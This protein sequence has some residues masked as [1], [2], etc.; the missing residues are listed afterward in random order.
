M[1]AL[2]SRAAAGRP[3]CQ[4]RC[5]VWTR[6]SRLQ[7]VCQI[8]STTEVAVHTE[9]L[10]FSR[11]SSGAWDSAAVGNPV[12]RC[13]M[14]DNE[15][16]WYMWYSGSS[17]PLAGLA[18]VAPAAGSIGVAVSHDG[19]DWLRGDGL[20][21][22][23]R[24]SAKDGDVGVV[25]GPNSDSWWALDTCH[26]AVSDV[27]VLS[28]SS[29][30]SG[31]GVYWM[32]YSGGDFEPVPAPPG[33]P[34][35]AAG[36]AVEGLRMRPGLAM[37]QDGR[38]WARIEADHHTWALFD[39]GEAGQ[40]D[41]AYIGHPQVLAAGPRDMRMYYHS[42]DAAAGKFKV[43]LATSKDGFQWSKAGP[44]FEGGAAAGDF[45]AAGAAACQ[46][47]RDPD[48]RQFLMFYEAV[49]ADG[50]R[51]IGLATSAD[52]RSNWKRCSQPILQP[53]DAADA[54]DAGGVGAP[55]AVAMSEGKWR[56]YYAGRRQQQ[57]PWEGIGVALG[58]PGEGGGVLSFKRRTGKKQQ[59]GEQQQQQ[60][61]LGELQ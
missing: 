20:V 54:W 61:M 46:V 1:Q 55:C 25:L 27:Q 3:L 42:F 24:G 12:V 33:L 16:R 19:I 6:R 58:G 4:H 11:G 8:S 21:E 22:G 29:V 44:V 51:S 37:S 23:H 15:Q 56:L 57:G 31:V 60:Q 36:D 48:S 43:G 10:V 14:G 2:Q 9:G 35:A 5:A 53:N 26:L 38:N 49:A 7:P 17:A 18:G 34:G 47:V 13:Y 45:D 50:S 40:W 39:V 52:G 59:Q 41:A 28:N 30:S 32:F